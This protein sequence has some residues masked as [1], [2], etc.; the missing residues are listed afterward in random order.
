[1][2]TDVRL[3]LLQARLDEIHAASYDSSDV[4]SCYQMLSL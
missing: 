3:L 4:I 2:V 1:M